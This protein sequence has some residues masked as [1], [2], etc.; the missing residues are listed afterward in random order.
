LRAEEAIVTMNDERWEDFIGR[1]LAGEDLTDDDRSLISDDPALNVELR[2]LDALADLDTQRDDLRERAV[3]QAALA[4][5]RDDQ[6]ASRSP[7]PRIGGSRRGVFWLAGAVAAAAAFAFV[8]RAPEP[9]PHVFEALAPIDTGTRVPF[10]LAEGALVVDGIASE[11]PAYAR[12]GEVVELVRGRACLELV[13]DVFACMGE[14]SKVRLT[15][16]DAADRRI[17]LLEGSVVVSLGKQPE[18][19][20]FSVVASGIWSR[21]VGTMFSVEV[22]DDGVVQTAVYEGIVE[23][24]APGQ[25][26]RIEAHKIGLATAR[27]IDVSEASEGE[28]HPEL[29]VIEGLSGRRA[30]P[31]PPAD[32]EAESAND[33]QSEQ[34]EQSV[35]SAKANLEPRAP[36]AAK[37]AQSGTVAPAP[38][39]ADVLL[40]KAREA[41]MAHDWQGAAAAYREVLEVHRGS[42]EA[43]T[44]LVSLGQLELDRLA[45]P[46]AALEHFDQYLAVSGPL[47]VEAKVGRIRALRAL[48][49]ADDEGRAI[50]AFVAAHPE[51]LEADALRR[52]RLELGAP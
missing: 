29:D 23:V 45:R 44:A 14:G 50:D 35:A 1:Q 51:S 42:P 34:S 33:E 30:A 26:E 5:L 49:R 37:A 22:S 11:R 20:S 28:R 7:L 48:G 2:V 3:A 19:V 27:G 41:R 39:S 43:R 8:V 6:R 36:S 12:V 25:G 47:A 38:R 9:E 24:G 40:A 17:D 21:A 16:L 52:R 31:S 18:G 32:V 46:A 4:R 13:G 10:A 15:E